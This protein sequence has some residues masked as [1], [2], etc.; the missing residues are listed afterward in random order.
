MG[1]KKEIQDRIDHLH[2]A[3]NLIDLRTS[4]ILEEIGELRKERV[5]IKFKEDILPVFEDCDAEILY[6]SQ[7][8]SFKFEFKSLDDGDLS[9]FKNFIE[10]N[11]GADQSVEIFLDGGQL[12]LFYRDRG[13]RKKDSVSVTVRPENYESL[14]NFLE[15][16]LSSVRFTNVD[17]RLEKKSDTIKS[18]ADSIKRKEDE[19]K[20]LEKL[21]DKGLL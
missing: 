13:D 12:R 15:D 20:N 7:K 17:E 9:K 21:K 2:T 11:D 3:L 16:S 10:S 4:K 1:R 19:R 6:L 14:E 8:P 5:R 18:K